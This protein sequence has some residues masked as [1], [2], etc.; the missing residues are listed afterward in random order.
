V[1]H[2][3]GGVGVM[4][5]VSFPLQPR[6]FS[7]RVRL[8]GWPTMALVFPTDIDAVAAHA[9]AT[10]LI[11]SHASD[12]EARSPFQPWVR[13]AYNLL[14]LPESHARELFNHSGFQKAIGAGGESSK[15]HEPAE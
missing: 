6:F 9:F 4:D 15:E 11:L 5:Q 12:A 14:K 10:M 2:D 3:A 8:N 13:I 1:S 7:V